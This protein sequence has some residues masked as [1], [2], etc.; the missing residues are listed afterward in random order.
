MSP[1]ANLTSSISK[2]YETVVQQWQEA[3]SLWSDKKGD[4]FENSHWNEIDQ[5]MRVLISVL[6]EL[7]QVLERSQAVS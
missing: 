2:E 4:E 5:G 3:H 6:E 7:Q 1:S